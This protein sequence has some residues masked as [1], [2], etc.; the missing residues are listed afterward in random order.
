[1]VVVPSHGS[2]GCSNDVLFIKKNISS[3]KMNTILDTYGLLRWSN[4]I[5]CE[6]FKG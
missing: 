1:M 5:Y 6:E 2:Y 3:S 4:G